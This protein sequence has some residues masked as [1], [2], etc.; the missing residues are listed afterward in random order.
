MTKDAA[1][2]FPAGDADALVEAVV[3]LLEDEPRRASL[4]AAARREAV[5]HYSWDD[6]ARRLDEIYTKVAA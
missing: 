2:S 1:V 6:I 4:G 3:G 5:D